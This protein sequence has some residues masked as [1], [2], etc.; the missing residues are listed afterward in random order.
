L[1]QQ[2]LL[3]RIYTQPDLKPQDLEEVLAMLFAH[4]GVGDNDT[5]KIPEPL[6]TAHVP[7][8]LGPVRP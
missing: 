6:T 7:H 3:R 8:R 5:T 1:W 4:V 2:D